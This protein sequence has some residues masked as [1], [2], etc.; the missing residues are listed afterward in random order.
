MHPYPRL[1]IPSFITL[2]NEVSLILCYFHLKGSCSPHPKKKK[3]ATACHRLPIQT[4]DVA[5]SQ[6]AT[7]HLFLPLPLH[8]QDCLYLNVWVPPGAHAGG[9]LP[10]RVYVHGGMINHCS[11]SDAQ[12]DGCAFTAAAGSIQVNIQVK[13]TEGRGVWAECIR[14]RT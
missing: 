13:K 2:R 1:L 7:C 8:S 12:T 5:R 14:K 3:P 11:A 4:R 10:V 6:T 9:R